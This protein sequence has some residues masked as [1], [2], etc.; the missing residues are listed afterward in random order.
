MGGPVAANVCPE[1]EI[2]LLDEFLN[3]REVLD[4]L[5]RVAGGGCLGGRLGDHHGRALALG[6][7]DVFLDVGVEVRAFAVGRAARAH[8]DVVVED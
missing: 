8:A 3:A 1:A 6:V 7:V 2:V 4:E 5:L